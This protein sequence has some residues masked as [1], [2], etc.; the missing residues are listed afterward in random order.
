VAAFGGLLDAAIAGTAL[1]AACGVQ[2]ALSTERDYVQTGVAGGIGDPWEGI[3]GPHMGARGHIRHHNTSCV[4]RSLLP[5]R[6][7]DKALGASSGI[8]LAPS[9]D[10]KAL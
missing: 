4:G 2:G 1:G 3:K 8:V 5:T 7:V 6:D 9:T 10:R